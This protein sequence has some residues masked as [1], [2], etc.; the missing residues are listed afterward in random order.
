[1]KWLVVES[2]THTIPH[3]IHWDDIFLPA[4]FSF[5][6]FSWFSRTVALI[7]AYYCIVSLELGLS[8]S[9]NSIFIL[10][11]RIIISMASSERVLGSCSQQPAL[12]KPENNNHNLMEGQNNKW[13]WGGCSPSVEWVEATASLTF[14]RCCNVSSFISE[15]F[16]V[17]VL[18]YFC[19]LRWRGGRLSESSRCSATPPLKTFHSS[20]LFT[21]FYQNSSTTLRVNG[22]SSPQHMSKS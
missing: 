10:F 2:L 14:P 11:F 12:I 8:A 18:F 9:L 20:A 4:F 13:L 5:S 19:L 21:H 16:S 22:P 1:M 6:G 15:F 17:F 7:W 3:H